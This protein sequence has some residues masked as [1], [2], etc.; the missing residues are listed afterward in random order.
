MERSENV[1]ATKV[2]IEKASAARRLV[3]TSKGDE[4]PDKVTQDQILENKNVN[5]VGSPKEGASRA[6]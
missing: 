5:P 1:D 6:A 4:G 2:E 3:I